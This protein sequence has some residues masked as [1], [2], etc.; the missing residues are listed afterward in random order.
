MVTLLFPEPVLLRCY[1]YQMLLF[2]NYEFLAGVIVAGVIIQ[3]WNP[4]A[5]LLI[6]DG[7][8]INEPAPTAVLL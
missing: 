8:I 2:P 4:I 7:L 5:V 3:C 6:P 1:Y